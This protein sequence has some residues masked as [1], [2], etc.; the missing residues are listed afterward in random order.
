VN[1]RYLWAINWKKSVQLRC[2]EIK[3]L[4][5]QLAGQLENIFRNPIFLKIGFL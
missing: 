3:Q 4:S 5:T 1:N 2:F